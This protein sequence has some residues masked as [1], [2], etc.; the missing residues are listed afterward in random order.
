MPSLTSFIP[1]FLLPFKWLPSFLRLSELTESLHLIKYV[2]NVNLNQW[3]SLISDD[4]TVA[5]SVVS[6]AYN[7]L[8]IDFFLADIVGFR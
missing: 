8:E 6:D 5:I 4:V 3:G 2:N 7:T 1:R